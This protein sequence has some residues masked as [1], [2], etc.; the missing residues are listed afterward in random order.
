MLREDAE[1]EVIVSAVVAVLLAGRQKYRPENW[2][3]ILVR[4]KKDHSVSGTLNNQRF[5]YNIVDEV[6]NPSDSELSWL[7]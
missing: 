1:R 2:D 5:G 3:W 4:L 6:S 7:T